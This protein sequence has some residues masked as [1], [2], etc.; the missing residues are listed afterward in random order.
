M[1]WFRLSVLQR[2]RHM[3]RT[4]ILN[5]QYLSIINCSICLFLQEHLVV[6]QTSEY[7]CRHLHGHIFPAALLLAGG[8]RLTSRVL[9][10]AEHKARHFPSQL[11]AAQSISFPVTAA[12]GA[13]S[14]RPRP[15]RAPAPSVAVRLRKLP[16][17]AV[18]A[19]APMCAAIGGA[20]P[21]PWPT[22]ARRLGHRCRCGGEVLMA[23]EGDLR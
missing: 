20:A 3:H 6:V 11:L 14:T 2:C 10:L 18:P 12:N 21:P 22:S 13:A 23:V 5:S 16:S 17:R 4:P 19:S 1:V 8:C 7:I 15:P 9:L